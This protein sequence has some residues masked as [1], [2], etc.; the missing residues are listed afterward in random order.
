[1]EQP[2]FLHFDDMTWP[3]PEDPLMVE[4]KLR[5][6]EPTKSDLM[7]AASMIAAYKQLVYDTQTRRNAKARGIRAAQ[8]GAS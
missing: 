4:W 8:A 2:G 5:H 1:M 6:G 7:V 3:N